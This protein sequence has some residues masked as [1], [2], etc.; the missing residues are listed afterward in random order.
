MPKKPRGLGQSPINIVA[1]FKLEKF[2]FTVNQHNNSARRNEA[3]VIQ[4]CSAFSDTILSS[5]ILA[6]C[7]SKTQILL[8]LF[9]IPSGLAS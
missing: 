4:N 8:S 6:I 9:F 1:Y 7:R 5:F 3:F 2:R